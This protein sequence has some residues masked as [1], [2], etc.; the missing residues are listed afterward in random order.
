MKKVVRTHTALDALLEK[1]C[2][3]LEVRNYSAFTIR[4][5]RIHLSYF[6][7]WASERGMTEPVEVTRTSLEQYRQ[8]VF[9]CVK[10]WRASRLHQSEKPPGSAAHLVS[11]DGSRAL[12]TPQSGERA[13]ASARGLSFA[14]G[15]AHCGRS[16]V[17]SIGF[18]YCGFGDRPDFFV[19]L[20]C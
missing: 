8:H 13:G 16:G 19:A 18:T 20:G 12:Y 17:E 7:T 11:L 15:R 10:E 3:H 5:Q 14:E 9:H 6:N 4:V 2:Q 1:Y